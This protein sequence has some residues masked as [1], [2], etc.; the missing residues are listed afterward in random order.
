MMKSNF[1]SEKEYYLIGDDG[2]LSYNNIPMIFTIQRDGNTIKLMTKQQELYFHGSF[3]KSNA[4]YLSSDKIS[5]TLTYNIGKCEIFR[6]EESSKFKW[7]VKDCSGRYLY[8]TDKINQNCSHTNAVF[9]HGSEFRGSF[10]SKY[11]KDFEINYDQFDI[12]FFEIKNNI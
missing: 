12:Q 11:C 8:I 9:M 5:P 7:R 1:V 10:I 2:I 6:I 3:K 4:I